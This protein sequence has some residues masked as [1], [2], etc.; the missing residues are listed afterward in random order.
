MPP[1]R[2]V[3]AA[4]IKFLYRLRGL[5]L[6]RWATG[7]A[8][9]PSGCGILKAREQELPAQGSRCGLGARTRS[10]RA[11]AR[12]FGSASARCARFCLR[13]LAHSQSSRCPGQQPAAWASSSSWRHRLRRRQRACACVLPPHA[14]RRKRRQRGAA[15]AP[16]TVQRRHEGLNELCRSVGCAG[17]G[18]RVPPGGFTS[19]RAD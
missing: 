15:C 10:P 14:L 2:H 11:L 7:L 12:H 16:P 13:H 8:P 19:E 18:W 9:T 17:V 4:T 1:S 6:A 5:S 3:V